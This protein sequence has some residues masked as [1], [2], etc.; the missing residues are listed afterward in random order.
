M[1]KHYG[2]FQCWDAKQSSIRMKFT[3]RVVDV[4]QSFGR[5]CCICNI[6]N[7]ET[8]PTH[9][10]KVSQLFFQWYTHSCVE[11][12][13]DTACTEP[14]KIT[15]KKWNMVMLEDFQTTSDA[16]FWVSFI[17]IWLIPTYSGFPARKELHW[18]MFER[19]KAQISVLAA[20]LQR[21]NGSNYA[22]LKLCRIL[23][24]CCFHKN[25]VWSR[26]TRRLLTD[27]EKKNQRTCLYRLKEGTA[28]V[29]FLGWSK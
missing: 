7:R 28:V 6:D 13:S 23:K 1:S 26:M 4:A 2:C 5:I 3:R 29:T 19:A 9:P 12:I 20:S 27:G 17:L 21:T 10:K 15:K 25:K 24:T 11:H 14:V 22:E 18:S 16:V 8:P